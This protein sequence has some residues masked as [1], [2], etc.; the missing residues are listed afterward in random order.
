MI[1][2]DL[3]YRAVSH[4]NGQTFILGDD[5]RYSVQTVKGVHGF[6]VFVCYFDGEPFGAASTPRQAIQLCMEVE[7]R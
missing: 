1:R 5:E 7:K 6:Q 3:D 2:H 4:P